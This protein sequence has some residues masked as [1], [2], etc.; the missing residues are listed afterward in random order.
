MPSE[1]QT[2]RCAGCAKGVRLPADRAVFRCPGCGHANDR[3]AGG[4]VADLAPAGIP[5]SADAPLSLDDEPPFAVVETPR[6][7]DMPAPVPPPAD[8]PV[9]GLTGP[10]V[11]AVC[12]LL[13]GVVLTLILDVHRP[14]V[15]LLGFVLLTALGG[16]ALLAAGVTRAVLGVVAAGRP[17]VLTAHARY[18]AGVAVAFAAGGF[19]PCVGG[20]VAEAVGPPEGYVKQAA[21]RRDARE[22]EVALA[23]KAKADADKKAAEDKDKAD[24][25]VAAQKQREK[26]R[27]DLIEAQRQFALKLENEKKAQEEWERAWKKADF[28]LLTPG[29]QA[30]AVRAEPGQLAPRFTVLNKAGGQDLEL[31]LRFAWEANVPV[32]ANVP[33]NLVGPIFDA[34]APGQ[35]VG[36]G[37]AQQ[38]NNVA[39]FRQLLPPPGPYVSFR[40]NVTTRPR[41]G[42]LLRDDGDAIEFCDL[43]PREKPAGG[44]DSNPFR[45]ETVKRADVTDYKTVAEG[46]LDRSGADTLDY[47]LFRALEKLQD[48]F[49]NNAGFQLRPCLYVDEVY[50]LSEARAALVDRIA[51]RDE[52]LRKERW[53][54]MLAPVTVSVP[55]HV[56]QETT[57]VIERLSGEADWWKNKLQLAQVS[58]QQRLEIEQELLAL[59][60]K[61]V[62]VDGLSREGHS[63]VEDMN[64]K[65][66]AAGIPIIDR[67]ARAQALLFQFGGNNQWARPNAAAAIPAGLN[68]ATHLLLADIGP[69]QAG[70]S[71][72]LSM[73]LIDVRTGQMLWTDHAD[74]DVYRGNMFDLPGKNPVPLV[75]E[76]VAQGSKAKL[77]IAESG[78]IITTSITFPAR[79][80]FKSADLVAE[81]NG[82]SLRVTQCNVSY[83][84]GLGY[85]PGLHAY[86]AEFRILDPNRIVI[87]T[88]VPAIGTR[89]PNGWPVLSEELDPAVFERVAPPPAPPAPPKKP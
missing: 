54:A 18:W 44:L 4:P 83:N 3:T 14:D 72:R 68:Q 65:V 62:L 78:Q 53:E 31:P 42:H 73:R 89:G 10:V 28:V 58:A 71:Y 37:Q 36:L 13:G 25:L 7:A 41:V 1:F 27:A 24:R 2:V 46:H 9:P 48:K 19:L 17:G 79:V 5:G 32:V 12:G 60:E 77:K 81:R 63:L 52:K 57:S 11:A 21:D 82:N 87:S 67:S 49:V 61:R 69:P 50:I 16:V 51:S 38:L 70:G 74:R 66:T 22:R 64:K 59:R 29:A 55:K 6:P 40:D 15:G 30:V 85:R 80:V 8:V 56:H 75:G 84:P 76:W 47:F 33:P 35:A 23:A 86:R 20:T 39:R 26:E 45:T 43:L 34:N 88:Q